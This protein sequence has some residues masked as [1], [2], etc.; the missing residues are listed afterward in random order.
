[1]SLEFAG[2]DPN[3]NHENCVTV[4]TDTGAGELLIQGWNADAETQA[5]CEAI[6]P[7]VGP[8][9]EGET[10]VRIPARMVPIL[11]EACDAIERADVRRTAG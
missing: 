7:A 3:T 11:R 1:M 4:W 6:S 10:I 9:P 2:I 8:V 5:A